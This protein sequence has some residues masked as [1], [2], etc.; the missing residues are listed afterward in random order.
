MGAWSEPYTDFVGVAICVDTFGGVVL[1]NLGLG[2][3]PEP[4]R[5]IGGVVI[6][7]GAWFS[8]IWIWGRGFDFIQTWGVVSTYLHI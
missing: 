4:Y 1:T 3:W 5:D 2:A 6:N 7:L 8:Q